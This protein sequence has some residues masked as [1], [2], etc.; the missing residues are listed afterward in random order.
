[1]SFSKMLH[2]LEN[3]L[4]Q[5]DKSNSNISARGVDWHLDHSLKIITA[6]CKTV[7]N[8]KPEYFK[9][10]FNISKYYILWSGRIPRGKARSPKPFNNLEA[11]DHS[12]LPQSLKEAQKS[13]SVLDSL[14]PNQH[15]KHP[16]FGDL[17]LAQ[18]KKFI[19]IHTA[20]H[21]DIIEEIINAS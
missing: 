11:I 9:P 2:R 1:M 16:M 18:S 21:L 5:A 19:H 7:S 10:N 3:A 4:P 8:S 15:F 13:L 12:S 14:H 6:I 20:H 17:N